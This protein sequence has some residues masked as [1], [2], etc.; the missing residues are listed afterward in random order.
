MKG[1]IAAIDRLTL[2]LKRYNDLHSIRAKINPESEPDLFKASYDA[3][4]NEDRDISSQLTSHFASS[5][6]LDEEV[7]RPNPRRQREVK[8]RGG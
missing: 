4:E 3:K 5:Q 2:E 1:L 6:P 8:K 7:E